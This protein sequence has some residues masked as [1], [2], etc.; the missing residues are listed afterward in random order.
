MGTNAFVIKAKPGVDSFLA[1]VQGLDDD[2]Y[3]SMGEPEQIRRELN[4]RIAA[5]GIAS[6]W[7]DES[8]GV[9]CPD[10][11]ASIDFYIHGGRV[12]S[13]LISRPTTE[14]LEILCRWGQMV[15]WRVFDVGSESEY[16]LEDMGGCVEE[17]CAT[18]P[19]AVQPSVVRR[20]WRWI[21]SAF[22]DAFNPETT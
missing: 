19:P 22:R 3:P 1:A 10:G 15:G 17:N 14:L 2:D 8:S 6:P 7:F 9:N 16:T 13:I 5:A 18:R 21:A 11:V 12:R 20:L 4:A